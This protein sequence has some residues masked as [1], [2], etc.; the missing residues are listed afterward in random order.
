MK[1]LLPSL[2]ALLVCVAVLWGWTDGFQAFTVFSHALRQAGPLPRALPDIPLVNQEGEAFSLKN[3][4]KFVLVNF[5]YLDCPDVCHKINNRLEGIYRTMAGKM[6]PENLEL[7]TISF[8]L[9][10]DD[11]RKIKSYKQLFG[12]GLDG[13]TFAL[14]DGI[15]PEKF[16]NFLRKIGVWARRVPGTGLINHSIYQFLV[17]PDGKIVK[18]F[19][20]ARE[21]DQK[22][23]GELEAWVS[24]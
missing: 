11:V 7:L 8:D 18:V 24:K 20:P 6:I 1:R 4:K 9:Q 22:I 13:W 10:R 2:A 3:K 21:N 5:V 16:D 17:A 14:P 19:D 23:M 12:K 15:S